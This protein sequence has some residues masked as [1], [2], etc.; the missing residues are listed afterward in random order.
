MPRNLFDR[1]EGEEVKKDFVRWTVPSTL[2]PNGPLSA[3]YRPERFVPQESFDM[4][5]SSFSGR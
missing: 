5:A 4:P 3:R 2:T 1:Q